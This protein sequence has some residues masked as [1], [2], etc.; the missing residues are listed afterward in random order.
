M[1]HNLETH[2]FVYATVCK[3]TLSVA[4]QSEPSF[5]RI[6]NLRDPAV[7]M[8]KSAP[9]PKSRIDLT[10][11]DDAILEKIK[12]AVTDCTSLVAYDPHSRPGVANLIEVGGD[13]LPSRLCASETA[14]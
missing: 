4:S 2:V 9:N 6:R 8:S 12:K 5:A 3:L 7:K 1:L 14:P 10:D 11:S 13:G